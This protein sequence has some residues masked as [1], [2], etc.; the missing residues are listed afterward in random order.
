MEQQQQ[1]Q[2]LQAFQWDC[3]HLH[4]RL[5][6]GFKQQVMKLVVVA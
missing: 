5:A 1:Q 2:R 4:F 3:L 6:A